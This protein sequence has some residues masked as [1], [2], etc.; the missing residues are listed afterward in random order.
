MTIVVKI[1]WNGPRCSTNGI[2]RSISGATERVRTSGTLI[3]VFVKF[4]ANFAVRYPKA[5]W[6]MAYDLIP[7][8][9]VC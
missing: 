8:N 4:P 9:F 7:T 2:N 6:P 1:E 5:K 3:F